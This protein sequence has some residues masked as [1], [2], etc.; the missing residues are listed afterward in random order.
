MIDTIKFILDAENTLPDRY[1]LLR[2]ED[3]VHDVTKVTNNVIRF[4][5]FAHSDDVITWIQ[6]NTNWEDMDRRSL[7]YHY[8]TVRGNVTSLID[9]WRF[10]LNDKQVYIVEKYCEHAMKLL[11]YPAV[12]N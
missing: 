1:M 5:G 9:S 2:Y 10:K 12:F 3:L 11:N 8:R 4:A 7:D 6:E